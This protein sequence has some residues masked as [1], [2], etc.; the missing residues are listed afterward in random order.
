MFDESVL[1]VGPMGVGKSSVAKAVASALGLSYVDVDEARWDYF[2]R[3]PD[4]DESTVDKLFGES[5]GAEA[6]RY[7]KPFEARYAVDIVANHPCAVLDFGAGY[8]VYQDM[9]LFDQVRAAFARHKHVVFLRYSEDP[10][11]SL[12]ALRA[13][14]ADVPEA[15]YEALNKEFILSP[16]NAMLATHT[17]D[18]KNKAIA[19]VVDLVLEAIRPS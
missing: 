2:S 15:L 1:F 13:R 4:Y 12:E 9:E 8:S 10:A 11:E 16:C 5:K 3:Q 7:M 14:H 17:I 6:F 18:T 19:E